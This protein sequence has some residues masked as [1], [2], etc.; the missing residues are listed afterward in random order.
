MGDRP[1]AAGQRLRRRVAA[2]QVCCGAIHFHAGAAEPAREFAD[3]NVAAFGRE[4]W[5]AIIVNVAGCGAMLKDYGHFWHDPEQGARE[6]FAGQV[7]DIHEFLDDLGLIPPQGEIPL[8]ATYHDACHLAHAQQI[9]EAPR[10]LLAQIPGP[11]APPAA[12]N[13][14]LLRSGREPTI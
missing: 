2:G 13:R 8:V 10:R 7:R 11:D 4:D 12:R 14:S 6:K 3:A 9:R 1:G 5:D